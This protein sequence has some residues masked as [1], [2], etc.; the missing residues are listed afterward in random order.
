[1]QITHVYLCFFSN[2]SEIP[3]LI[4]KEH[5]HIFFCITFLKYSKQIT[6]ILNQAPEVNTTILLDIG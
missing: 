5:A 6:M 3:L 2:T 4:P 1:M